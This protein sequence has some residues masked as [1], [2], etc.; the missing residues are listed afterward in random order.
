MKY[1]PKK[2][3]ILKPVKSADAHYLVYAKA[4]YFPKFV[5]VY[6]PNVPYKKLYVGLESAD[7]LTP[8]I[9]S[10]RDIRESNI[11][12]SLRLTRKKIKE[13]VF[14]NDFELFAT[15][16]FKD[17]RYD[18]DRSKTKMTNWLK[19][20]RRRSGS[21]E[22]LLVPEFHKDKK[23]IHFHALIKGYS[24]VLVPAINPRTGK[25]ITKKERK[26]YSLKSYRLGFSNVKKIDSDKDSQTK[27]GFY[28]MKYI[29]KDMPIFFGKN[30]YRASAG[31]KKP[32]AEENP[33][34]WYRIV[35]PSRIYP[36][37]N[38]RIM[39]FDAGVH[40]L[41]DIYIEANQ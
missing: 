34:P 24:G 15:F 17:D 9:T 6:I 35:E 1:D 16:T 29:T 11:E 31:L 21:F 39:E 37:E 14:C 32:I 40:P 5:S 38:G 13:Y 8:S 20:Q 7:D 27:V 41:V 19:N 4:T 36:L 23:A 33:E 30:R 25:Q 18:V 2:K 22:Y 3:S 12:R 28:L 26:Y 10:S